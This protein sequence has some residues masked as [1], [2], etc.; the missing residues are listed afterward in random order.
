MICTILI[1]IE[2]KLKTY[3]ENTNI[4]F[5]QIPTLNNQFLNYV[6]KTIIPYIPIFYKPYVFNKYLV[7]YIY[8]FSNRLQIL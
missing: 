4:H 3:T 2:T 5:A 1:K 7:S 8:T 6:F